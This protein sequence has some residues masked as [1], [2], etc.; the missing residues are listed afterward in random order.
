MLCRVGNAVCCTIQGLGLQL[1]YIYKHSPGKEYMQTKAQKLILDH[2]NVVE[3]NQ[4]AVRPISGAGIMPYSVQLQADAATDHGT[5][6]AFGMAFGSMS[7]SV[8]GGVH[9][10]FKQHAKAGFCP[11]HDNSSIVVH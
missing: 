7:C 4:W 3:S 8:L 5:A 2:T 6:S 9:V 11:P 1:I 10:S